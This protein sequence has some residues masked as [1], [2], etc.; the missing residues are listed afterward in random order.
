MEHSCWVVLPRSGA[1]LRNVSSAVAF[2]WLLGSIRVV[3]IDEW[4]VEALCNGIGFALFD[5]FP[6]LAVE[7]LVLVGAFP[8]KVELPNCTG[9]VLANLDTQDTTE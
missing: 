6:T 2:K 3:E 8:G 5:G 1:D 4:I 7:Q 9:N